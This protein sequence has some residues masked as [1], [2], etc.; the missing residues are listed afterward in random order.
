MLLT[1][2]VIPK[3]FFIV[4]LFAT[5]LHYSSYSQDVTDA[6][7]KT[8]LIYKFYKYITWNNF[9]DP[10]IFKIGVFGND[11]VMWNSLN[12]LNRSKIYNRRIALYKIKTVDDYFKTDILYV[13]YESNDKISDLYKFVKA[14]ST[15]LIT[16][17]YDNKREVMINFI[18]DANNKVQFEL[19]SKNINDIHLSISPKLLLLGGTELD[20]RELYKETEKSLIN[21]R[22]Y[23]EKLSKDL[24]EK[25]D[26]VK[27]LTIKLDKLYSD[28]ESLNKI[29]DSQVKSINNQQKNLE[30]LKINLQIIEKQR[31]IQKSLLDSSTIALSIK[32]KENQKL[33]SLLYF[34]Q[35]E[36]EYTIDSLEVLTKE[37]QDKEEILDMQ[38][39]KIESQRIFLIVIFAFFIMAI[40]LVINIYRISRIKAQRNIELEKRNIQINKQKN[41][42]EL[43]ANQLKLTN[44]ELEKLSIVAEKTD[45]AVVIM[46]EKGDIEWV[47]EGFVRMTGYTLDEFIKKSGKNFIYAS[48]SKNSNKIFKE[49]IENKTAINYESYLITKKGTK[50]WLQSTITP[51]VNNNNNVIK[52]VAIDT[53]ITGL[54]TAEDKIIKKNVEI[55]EK[56]KELQK[57]TVILK[58]SNIE[59]EEQKAKAEEALSLLKNTQ[60][61]LVSAEKMASL[62][63]L[64]S[65]IAHEINN[66]INYISSSIEGLKLIISDV[67]HL[68]TEYNSI[69][70]ENLKSKLKYIENL[71][72]ELEYNE[73]LNGFDE[74]TMNIKLG[75]DR[76]KEI[77]NSLRTFSRMDEDNYTL[78]NLN[79]NIDSTLILLGKH[80]KDRIE[81]IKNF[82]DIPSI[83][84][85]SSKISQVFLNILVNAIQ[86]IKNEGTIKISTKTEN[87]KNK[88]YVCINIED[89]GHG[90]TE[91]VKEKIFEPFFTTKDVGQGTGLGLSI[92]YS[93]IKKH[94]GDIQVNSKLGKGT[95]FKI[96]L[97]VKH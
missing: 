81:I 61:Q 68:L 50:K 74:L 64:T 82:D 31:L 21:E 70:K 29:I 72:N 48:T 93:I 3:I 39:V 84:C 45:N 4:F 47:N 94:G 42:I 89:T 13:N 83:E 35:M 97:P 59:L 76:T 52:L 24:I 66:P 40:I 51:I 30:K 32:N 77:V 60:S 36:I 88:E 86:S 5:F 75:I 27:K 85:I 26:E 92:A 62:G 49:C 54:K 41:K 95:S 78:V 17:R 67:K 15:L 18:H 63:Q 14:D 19:N 53:D 9:S 80:H 33:D 71:K 2:K 65:G 38:S 10:D 87:L 96:K 46:D 57:Q 23:S 44:L 55:Q 73:L 91:E 90:I 11:P 12:E 25:E 7:I 43:Q 6:D 69:N 22:E 1:H 37:I 58:K 34:K 16:D 28:I 20:V 79:N 56:A 8:A